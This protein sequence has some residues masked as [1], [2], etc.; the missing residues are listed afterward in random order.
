MQLLPDTQDREPQE[1][2]LHRS[3]ASGYIQ[4][5]GYRGDVAPIVVSLNHLSQ[6]LAH[7]TEASSVDLAVDNDGSLTVTG[8]SDDKV[9]IDDLRV[10]TIRPN[11]TWSR[12][13]STGE[14][15]VELDAQL[16]TGINVLGFDL[17][18][19]P[20]LRCE[21]LMLATHAGV[22]FRNEVRTNAY[23]SPRT[24]F[25]RI[26]TLLPEVQRVF[27]TR[28]GYWGMVAGG[29]RVLVA[30]HHTGGDTFDLYN[31]GASALGEIPAVRLL[32]VLHMASEAAPIRLLC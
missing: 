13:H 30:G 29:M 18:I 16:F 7:G 28:N 21:R 6:T 31:M 14:E 15:S 32:S 9:D 27:M 23:P 8:T 24:D 4:S 17:V 25:L 26:P 19:P 20:V 12:F 3:S 10:H 2:F 5:L 22:V 1:P 11:V